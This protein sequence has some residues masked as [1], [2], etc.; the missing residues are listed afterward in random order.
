MDV[1][2][3]ALELVC[4]C[5]LMM[6][7]F[8]GGCCGGG[9]N[10]AQEIFGHVRSLI[11]SSLDGFNVCIFAYGQTGSGKTFT[12]TGPE[13]GLTE[14][15]WLHY[16]SCF[17]YVNV[18]MCARVSVNESM[19]PLPHFCC[20]FVYVQLCLTLV[21]WDGMWMYS[22][23]GRE[24]WNEKNFYVWNNIILLCVWKRF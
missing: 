9:V 13:D 15:V 1:C 3:C 2:D 11:Q 4:P 22:C 10:W 5:A 17:V 21:I 18:Y 24:L 19:L 23:T 8:F 20:V 12:M 16:S 6:I 7:H 14:G